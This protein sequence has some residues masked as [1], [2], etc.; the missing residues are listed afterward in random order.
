[1][2]ITLKTNIIVVENY[3]SYN[4]GLGEKVPSYKIRTIV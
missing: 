1:M 4:Y 2:H 3:I